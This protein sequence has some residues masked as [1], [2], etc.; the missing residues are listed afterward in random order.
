MLIIGYSEHQRPGE[1][2]MIRVADESVAATSTV[3]VPVSGSDG[4]DEVETS[5]SL[6]LSTGAKF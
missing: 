5:S 3:L 1:L 4:G 2:V 6:E